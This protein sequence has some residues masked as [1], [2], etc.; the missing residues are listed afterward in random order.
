MGVLL[1]VDGHTIEDA[2]WLRKK[3]DVQHINVAE[4]EAA[5]RGVKM[6]IEWGFKAFT[7]A[8]DSRTVVSWLQS[9]ITCEDRVRTKSAAALLVKR[10]LSTLREMIDEFDLKIEIE[11]VPTAENLADE[12]TRV[13]KRWL[14]RCPE[15][16]ESSESPLVAA[17]TVGKSTK[18]AIGWVL[19]SLTMAG[20][21]TC[22]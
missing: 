12:L 9:A 22:R 5:T 13:P 8:T 16:E 1:Q 11:F 4:L 18:D 14:D 7:L 3:T 21:F 15:Q 10:R 6:A 20:M 2:A 19:T 17:L